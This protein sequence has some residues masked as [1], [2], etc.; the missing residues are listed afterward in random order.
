M[1]SDFNPYLPYKKEFSLLDMSLG[2]NVKVNDGVITGGDLNVIDPS[3]TKLTLIQGDIISYPLSAPERIKVSTPQI[4]NATTDGTIRVIRTF[5]P[6]G[7]T[8]TA[9]AKRLLGNKS[10]IGVKITYTYRDEDIVGLNENTLKISYYDASIGSASTIET[11][12]DPV[13]N[14]LEGYISHFSETAIKGTPLPGPSA[15]ENW[16]LYE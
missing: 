8:F 9:G 3:G 14:T 4:Q 12:V 11:L 7:T 2:T 15:V 16:N 6:T 5:E 10:N 1:S 13:N